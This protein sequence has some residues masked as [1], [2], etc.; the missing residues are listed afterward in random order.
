MAFIDTPYKYLV[1][2]LLIINWCIKGNRK[3]YLI[4]I[5][6]AANILLILNS[7]FQIRQWLG[8][9]YLAKQL[10]ISAEHDYNFLKFN[11]QLC[12]QLLIIMLPLL[13]L[14]KKLSANLWL[15][16]LML[17]LLWW[18]DIVASVGYYNTDNF[19][20]KILNYSCLLTATYALLWLQ[21][22]LPSQLPKNV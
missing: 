12:L 18:N 19:I 8:M 10:N 1:L 16:I 22:R 14:F 5:I 4:N 11:Y 7:V 13:F 6:T 20:F 2:L 21:K 9:Y 17:I 15:T 3:F